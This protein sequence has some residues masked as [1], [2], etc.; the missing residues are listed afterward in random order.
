MTCLI[1]V[2]IAGSLQFL[3]IS[4]D[5]EREVNTCSLELFL[6]GKNCKKGDNYM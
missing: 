4:N 6:V 5:C 1:F 2:L 3:T